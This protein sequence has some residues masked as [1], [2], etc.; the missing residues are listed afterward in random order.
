M[1]VYLYISI[2]YMCSSSPFITYH[3]L[4]IQ[5]SNQAKI[6]HIVTFLRHFKHLRQLRSTYPASESTYRRKLSAEIKNA[7]LRRPTHILGRPKLI[8]FHIT[9]VRSTQSPFRSTYCCYISKFGSVG[10]PDPAPLI[11]NHSSFHSLSFSY[12]CV[13]PTLIPQAQR[14]SKIILLTQN[15]LQE[16][17]Q[18]QERERKLLLVHH[19][20]RI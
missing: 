3:V 12:Y 19:L 7:Q 13:R 2:T 9:S 20:N 10:R 4:G 14:L 18:N 17:L 6:H 5:A 11:H 16:C 15:H 8:I 1:Y